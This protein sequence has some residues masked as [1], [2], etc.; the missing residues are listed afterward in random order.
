MLNNAPV[1]KKLR[2][3]LRHKIR[4]LER[5]FIVSQETWGRVI[6]ERE[7]VPAPD[8]VKDKLRGI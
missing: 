3:G 2:D 5:R 7:P 4:M 1:G 6:R 8:G